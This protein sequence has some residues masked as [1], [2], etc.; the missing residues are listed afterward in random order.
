MDSQQAPFNVATMEELMS[1]SISI[2]KFLMQLLI[3]LAAVAIVM[4]GAGIYGLLSYNVA[5]RTQEIGIRMALGANRR[6]IFAH[7]L[8]SG[9]SLTVFGIVLGVAGSLAAGRLVAGLL[10]QTSPSDAVTLLVVSSV[11]LLVA[12][13][14]CLAPARRASNLQPM[15]AI[16]NE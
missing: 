8:K 6:R 15:I 3:A 11:L 5:R 7:I 13:A 1:R 4:A 2:N 10:F 16:R 12:L 9:M 14:A